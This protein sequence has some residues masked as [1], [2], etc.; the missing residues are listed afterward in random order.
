MAQI[1][2]IAIVKKSPI[3]YSAKPSLQSVTSLY[4][5]R[6]KAMIRIGSERWVNELTT[7]EWRHQP[8]FDP[9]LVPSL[10]NI[11]EGEKAVFGRPKLNTFLRAT[12]ER[13]V[14]LSMDQ[15]KFQKISC[16]MH[17]ISPLSSVLGRDG[18]IWVG[19]ISTCLGFCRRFGSRFRFPTG[20]ITIRR[21]R[22]GG[23]C[24]STS[25]WC[26]GW[27]ICLSLSG[28]RFTSWLAWSFCW[29]RKRC[30]RLLQHR[31]N[32]R[33]RRRLKLWQEHHSLRHSNSGNWA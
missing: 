21:R 33:L 24:S 14:N 5:T 18:E 22:W 23:W 3:I 1:R 31:H 20:G 26:C 12:C 17:Q 28:C 11:S 10:W 4:S 29:F 9:L 27:R 32:I 16:D 7:H 19:L 25:S 8:F 13:H 15:N 6:H 2:R 30:S